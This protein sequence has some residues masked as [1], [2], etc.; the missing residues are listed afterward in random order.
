MAT[1][2]HAVATFFG[3]VY[4]WRMPVAPD[5]GLFDGT[6]EL[7]TAPGITRGTFGYAV[8]YLGYWLDRA[9]RAHPGLEC[10]DVASHSTGNVLVRSYIQSPAYGGTYVD[11]RGVPRKLPRIRY[12]IAG[13]G[14]NEGTIHSWRPWHADFQDVLSGFIPTTKIEG[15]FA[16]VAFATVIG[17]GKI[18]GPDYAITRPMITQIDKNGHLAP[19]P[20]TFFRLYNPM[21]QRLMPTNDF[22][23]R[24]GSTIPIDVN[25]DPTLRS[26]VQLDLNA[27]S[28]EGDNPWAATVGVPDGAGGKA[29]G[30]IAAFATGARGRRACPTFASAGSST[31]S[32]SSAPPSP[33]IRPSRGL[34]STC[35]CWSCSSRTPSPSARSNR[36]FPASATPSP[37]SSSTG[38]A[39]RSWIRT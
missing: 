5:D 13:A 1:G 31:S 2:R 15:R 7:V 3:A 8:N 16:A 28:T 11:A 26:D 14:I 27:A 38:T 17:G 18:T 20:V 32:A 24:P 36:G 34:G 23:T 12:Y 39:T 33:S 29:G 19:D 30:V 4:D 25:S 22:L 21:R 37:S 6:L 35:P 10:V 9:V